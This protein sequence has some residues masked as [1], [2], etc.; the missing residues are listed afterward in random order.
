MVKNRL[1]TVIVRTTSVIV[2]TVMFMKNTAICKTNEE[3]L[4]NVHYFVRKVESYGGQIVI[5]LKK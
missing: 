4:E 2:R 3:C 5:F 1:N